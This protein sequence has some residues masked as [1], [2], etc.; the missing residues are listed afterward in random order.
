MLLARG[1]FTD[2]FFGTALP[3][4]NH[5][6]AQQTQRPAQYKRLFR[7]LS[8]SRSIE[9]V[10]GYTGVGL[11][12]EIGEGESITYDRPVQG[13]EKTF[14]HRK[15]GLGIKVTQEMVE[16]EKF[17]LIGRNGTALGRSE[18]ES[19]ETM[20]GAVFN[21]AFVTTD[22]TT[23]DGKALC[24]SDHVIPKTG[25]A[26]SNLMTP[27]DLTVETIRV[28]LLAYRAQLDDTGQKVRLPKPRLVIHPDN[29]FN[30]AEI[31]NSRM[32]PDT[33]NNVDNAL[34]FAEDGLP[35]IIEWDYLTD[36][37]AW[38]LVAP[39]SAETELVTYWR[40]QPWSKDWVDDPTDT[41]HTKRQ[42]RVSLGAGHYLGVIGNAGA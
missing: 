36:A 5:L 34:K 40:K 1:E 26:Q 33:A 32:R 19:L 7:Q 30:A 25:A 42:F 12:R 28:A 2:F 38:F 13:F 6:I 31:V 24:A 29:T 14:T 9:Q 3:A 37:D 16:D 41:A 23:P 27:A 39:P 11:F 8:S 4:L 15:Y 18:R 17:G 35:E 21:G 10:T 20:H 22:F